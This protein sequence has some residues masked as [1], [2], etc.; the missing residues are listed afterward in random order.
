MK[1]EIYARVVAREISFP[2][3]IAIDYHE[4]DKHDIPTG[5]L[6]VEPRP[7]TW[8]RVKYRFAI[9]TAYAK[10]C[11]GYFAEGRSANLGSKTVPGEFLEPGDDGY[12]LSLLQLK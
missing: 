7:L 10:E 2:D 5:V 11:E 3:S 4:L 1:K 12:E 9:D 6:Y 8:E